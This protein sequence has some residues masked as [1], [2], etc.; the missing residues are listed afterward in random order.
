MS[1]SKSLEPDQDRHLVSFDLGPSCLQMLSVYDTSMQDH[2]IFP[3]HNHI[4]FDSLS[5]NH[6]FIVLSCAFF[7]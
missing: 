3:I 1:M 5:Y 2:M 7:R 4:T 6:T